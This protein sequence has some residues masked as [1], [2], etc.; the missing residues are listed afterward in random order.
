MDIELLKTFLEVN[1]TR[2]FGKAAEH[3]FLT[4]SAVSARIRQL[5]QTL[6]VELF[7][8]TRNNV[9]LTPQ[10]ER[11]RR[12]AEAILNTWTR[13]RQEIAVTGNGTN[14]LAVGSV[15]SLWDICLKDWLTQL[16]AARPL[17]SV[18]A[19]A[20]GADV[21]LRRVRERTLDLAFGFESPQLAEIS[22]VELMS[23]RLVM[24]SS[25]G[26]IDPMQALERDDYVLVDWGTGFA[27]AHA[28]AF[29]SAPPPRLRIGLGRLARDFVLD[30]GGTAYLPEAMV[31]ADV[32]S[33]RLLP[34]RGAPLMERATYAFHHP[35][36]NHQGR[37][38]SLLAMLRQPRA[39]TN[40]R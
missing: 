20:H 2:H 13:A 29:G 26:G 28:Q 16:A 30:H 21:L 36:T 14:T 31:A 15:P 5:E 39:A 10:G 6:G 23:I 22:V 18:T 25:H 19:E 12:Y 8:R 1:R 38:E 7:T 11:L 17:L 33:G 35:E 4:Q 37:I 9:Q 40:S 34:V 24:V 32:A 3:L 27:N